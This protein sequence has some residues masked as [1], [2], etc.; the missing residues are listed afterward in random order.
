MV[1]KQRRD[2]RY[3]MIIPEL[4]EVVKQLKP[5]YNKYEIDELVLQHNKTVLRLS[6][7]HCEL[8]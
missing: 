7:Y 8:N 6:P 2:S 5:L 1:R 4:L 3:T